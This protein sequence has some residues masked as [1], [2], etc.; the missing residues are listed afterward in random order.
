[1]RCP[2]LTADCRC[3]VHGTSEMPA[4]CA[5]LRPLPEMCGSSRAQALAYLEALEAATAPG[6]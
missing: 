6:P 5:A 1:M 4:V 2:L 3:S